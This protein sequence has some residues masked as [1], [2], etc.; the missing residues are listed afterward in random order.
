MPSTV[1]FSERISLLG[2]ALE[3]HQ[4]LSRKHALEPWCIVVNDL[5]GFNQW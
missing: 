2:I 4:C 1:L 5:P 3:L